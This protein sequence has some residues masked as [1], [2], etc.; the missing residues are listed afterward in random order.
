MRLALPLC[1]PSPPLVH[2]PMSRPGFSV[3]HH[4]GGL[5]RPQSGQPTSHSAVDLNANS[6]G[7]R[8]G[9]SGSP[10]LASRAKPVGRPP[11]EPL[12]IQPAKP[13]PYENGGCGK[14]A[15]V[16]STPILTP[17]PSLRGSSGH[18]G[19][20]NRHPADCP[21]LRQIVVTQ[22]DGRR[23]QRCQACGRVLAVLDRVKR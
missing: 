6:E 16:P 10:Q 7:G 9:L 22:T 21:H 12:G 18:P 15:T 11:V 13:R 14:G 4:W 3:V 23:V 2:T 1:L 5:Y 19:G 17:C 20:R 8:A